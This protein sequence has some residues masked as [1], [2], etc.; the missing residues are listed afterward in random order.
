MIRTVFVV[1][2]LMVLLATGS[3]ASVT[4]NVQ[5]IGA[6]TTYTYTYLNTDATSDLIIG[7]HVYAPLDPSLVTGWNA[8]SGWSL[9]VDIDPTGA[10]DIYWYTDDPMGCGIIG[11]ESL[12]FSMTVPSYTTTVYDYV[13]EDF[14]VTNWG[15]DGF[16]CGGTWLSLGSVPVPAGSPAETP[17]PA[18][19]IA[20]CG[21]CAALLAKR[22]R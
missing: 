22:K 15:Y 18:S 1:P 2:L 8:A 12:D 6:G 21:G 20:L 11:G 9:G 10:S 19:I 4:W 14:P 16:L 7:F 13:V 17:E 5:T 3:I